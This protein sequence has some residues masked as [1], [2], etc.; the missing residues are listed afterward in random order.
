M[1][2]GSME[3]FSDVPAVWCDEQNGSHAI[4]EDDS[5]ERV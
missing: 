2:R 4:M 1:R 5:W 3:A